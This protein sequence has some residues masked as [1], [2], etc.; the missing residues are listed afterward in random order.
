[1]TPE[2]DSPYRLPPPLHRWMNDDGQRHPVEN[3][4]ALLALALGMASLVCLGL[5]AWDAAGWLSLAAGLLAAYD[6]FIAKTSGERWM[7]L[8]AFLLATICLAVS[9][10]NGGML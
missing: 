9:M 1:V 6:E 2:Q 10:A 3:T 5:R 8:L 4:L 7:I